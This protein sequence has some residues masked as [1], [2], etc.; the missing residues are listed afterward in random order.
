MLSPIMPYRRQKTATIAKLLGTATG[1]FLG[2]RVAE[3]GIGGGWAS[4]GKAARKPISALV[5]PC[6]QGC[7]GC[8]NTVVARITKSNIKCGTCKVG[9]LC[10]P[11]VL[12]ARAAQAT[13][14]C[15][16]LV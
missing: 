3:P 7:W 2:H 6:L 10:S 16:V 9:G 5:E 14:P 8:A 1:C 13:L 15:R 12:R 4:D 11:C